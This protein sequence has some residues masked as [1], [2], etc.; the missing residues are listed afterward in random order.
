MIGFVM[1]GTNDLER[2]RIFYD[3]V[4]GE[5][6][7]L[8]TFVGDRYI[9]YS[10]E[11][12]PEKIEIYITKPFN[13][14]PASNGNGSMIALLANSREQVNN[15]HSIALKNGASNEGNPGPRPSDSKSYYSYIRD[16]S[17]NKICVFTTSS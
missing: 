15:F 7:F 4:L 8:R 6:N 5:L 14:E 3:I 17:G 13:K 12:K 11:N 9:G 1:I 10:E 2:S 16:F